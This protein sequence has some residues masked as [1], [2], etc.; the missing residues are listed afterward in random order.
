MKFKIF[1]LVMIAAMI[2][3]IG[4]AFGVEA[5]IAIIILDAAVYFA[6]NQFGLIK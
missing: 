3:G 2:I 4:I 5:L 1:L 6:A